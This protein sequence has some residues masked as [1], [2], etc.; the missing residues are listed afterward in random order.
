MDKRAKSSQKVPEKTDRDEKQHLLGQL[1]STKKQVKMAN[2]EI[3]RLRKLIKFYQQHEEAPDEVE[4]PPLLKKEKERKC[5]Y[6]KSTNVDELEVGLSNSQSRLYITCKE[7]GKR[8]RIDLDG[9][10]ETNQ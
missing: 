2:R 3:A 8:S 10:L 1:R 7:C 4:L 9:I 6:C 5:S